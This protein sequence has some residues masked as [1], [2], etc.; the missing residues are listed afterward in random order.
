MFVLHSAIQ[1]TKDLVQI[2]SVNPYGN[3]KECSDY[4]LEWLEGIEGISVKVQSVEEHRNNIIIKYP[5]EHSSLPPLVIISHMDTVP[6]EGEW[7]VGPYSGEIIDGKLYGRGSCDMKSGLAS[8]LVALKE[9][10]ES[11][12]EVKRDIY[13]IASVDEEGPYMKGAVALIEDGIVPED[14][15]FLATEPTSLTLSKVHKGTIW[16]KITVIGKSSHCGNAK[17]G[18]DVAHAA[19]ECITDLKRNVSKLEYNH[20]IFGEPTLSVGTIHGGEKTN[21]VSGSVQ[22]E[23]DFRLVPP[24]TQEEAEK[25]VEQS[26]KQGCA[27]VTGSNFKIEQFG[28]A[29]I[30]LE[31][32]ENSNLLARIEHAYEASFQT[33]IGHSGFPAYTDVAMIGLKTGNKNIAVFGPGNLEQAHMIDEYVEVQQ[34]IDCVTVLKKLIK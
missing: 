6:A 32:D 18:I 17:L 3:E 10:A 30:P 29:R 21:M 27:R 33:D 5:C 12:T 2:P 13:V 15:H 28:F 4:I 25:I 14:A 22:F 19:A 20:E 9:L 23:I 34:I 11:K 26:L 24:M 7:S 1:L 31:S 16:Y 8:T